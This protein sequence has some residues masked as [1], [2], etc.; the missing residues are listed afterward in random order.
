MME[1]GQWLRA[2]R[3]F[4][5][6]TQKDLGERAQM[7][8]TQVCNLEKTRCLYPSHLTLKRIA[9]GFGLELWEMF[10]FM[11]RGDAADYRPEEL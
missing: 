6:W 11:E 2:H 4:R 5:G 9:K 1:F 3:E 8:R 10:F 7:D